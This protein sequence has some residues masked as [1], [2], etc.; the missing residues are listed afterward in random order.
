MRTEQPSQRES[1]PAQGSRRP[2][3]GSGRPAGLYGEVTTL[4]VS[5]RGTAPI[6]EPRTFV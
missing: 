1:E 2:A 5:G 3:A 4:P 6:A